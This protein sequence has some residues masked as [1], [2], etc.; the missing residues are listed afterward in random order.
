[1]VFVRWLIQKSSQKSQTV[2]EKNAKH[3]KFVID[4]VL[5][6][7]DEKLSDEI[8]L[9]ESESKKTRQKQS[10]IFAITNNCGMMVQS[11]EKP[12]LAKV[13]S[14]LPVFL[15]RSGA[16]ASAHTLRSLLHNDM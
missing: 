13:E 8:I 11:G 1:M 7:Y 6:R 14:L 5:N 16:Q 3:R 2:H 4:E 12:I 10:K 15:R 9:E